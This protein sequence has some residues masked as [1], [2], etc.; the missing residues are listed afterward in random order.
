VKTP[1]EVSRELYGR[2]PFVEAVEIARYLRERSVPTDRIAVIGSEP[3][4]YFYARRPAATGYIY[5]YPL[6]EAQRY[7]GRMQEEMIREI[8]A[9]SPAYLVFVNVSTSWLVRPSFDPGIL[10]WLRRYASDF[11]V[12]AVADIVSVERTEYR[13]DAEARNY[14]PKSPYSVMVFRR[15]PT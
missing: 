4:I 13:W 7:A 12:V 15:K 11:E 9:A 14:A 3:E 10:T 5:T 6:M 2:N 8:E 1:T